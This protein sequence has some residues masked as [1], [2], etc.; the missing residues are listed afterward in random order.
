MHCCRIPFN[1]RFG[2]RHFQH[3]VHRHLGREDGTT[4]SMD[5]HLYHV[6]LFQELHSFNLF[7]RNGEVAQTS[8][9]S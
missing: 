4:L 1:S 5:L 6:A 3:Y 9:Y 2:V 8:R 7:T